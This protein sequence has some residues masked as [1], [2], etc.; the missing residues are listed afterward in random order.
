MVLTRKNQAL[1]EENKRKILV[2]DDV[3]FS[4]FFLL[5]FF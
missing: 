4:R 3:F 2:I 5:N 1:E